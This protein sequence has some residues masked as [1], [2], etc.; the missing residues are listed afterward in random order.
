LSALRGW[1]SGGIR[2]AFSRAV[3]LDRRV[4][5]ALRPVAAAGTAAEYA[6]ICAA[7]ADKEARDD[8]DAVEGPASGCGWASVAGAARD[9]GEVCAVV[10]MPSAVAV[11]GGRG[12]RDVGLMFGIVVRL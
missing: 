6:D 4:R 12:D 3:R 1:S 8:D 11:A 7:A 10:I 9:A 5:V 2:A